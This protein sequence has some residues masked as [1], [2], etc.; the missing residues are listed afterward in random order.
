MVK[1]KKS[2]RSIKG[3]SEKDYN[4]SGNSNWNVRKIRCKCVPVSTFLSHHIKLHVKVLNTRC[5][6]INFLKRIYIS[7]SCDNFKSKLNQN[8]NHGIVLEKKE[9]KKHVIRTTHSL[10]DIPR[11][12]RHE[13]NGSENK[14]SEAKKCANAAILGIMTGLIWR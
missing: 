7:S 5:R 1:K 10:A 4:Y 13:A 9:Q 11:V 8:I 3:T 2:G 14:W 6:E 12:N